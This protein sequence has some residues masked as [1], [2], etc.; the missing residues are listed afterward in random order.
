MFKNMLKRSWLSTVRKPSRT[1]ILMLVLFVMANMLLATIAIKGAVSE[2]VKYAKETLGGVVYLQPDMES[3]REK[4]MANNGLEN[5]T[6]RVRIERPSIS[7]ET[8]KKIADSE[9]VKD[10]TYS[11]QTS[12]N[13]SGFEL[14]E[15]EQQQMRDRIKNSGDINRPGGAS[16]GFSFA[17]GDTSIVGI[18]SFAFITDVETGNMKLS[19]GKIFDENTEDGVVV[20]ADLASH[21][22]L[23]VGSTIKLNTTAETP[24]EVSLK[25]IGIF[26]NTNDSYDPNTIY[27]NIDTAAKLS[28]DSSNLGVQSVKYYLVNAEDKDAFVA[29]AKAKYPSLETDGLKIDIDTS[30]YDQM[31]GPI[32][33]VGSFATTILWVVVI[34]SI[35]IITLIV[36]INVKDRRYEMGV[37]LSLGAKRTNILGQVLLELVLVGTVAFALSIGTGTFIAR[38]MGDGLLKQQVAMNEDSQEQG[39]GRGQ[40]AG[41]MR[42]GGRMMMG[43]APAS[44]RSVEVIKEIDVNASMGDYVTLFAAGYAVLIVALVLPSINILRYQP[45]TILTSKE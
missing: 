10:Y 24:E 8:A 13:A 43:G 6:Q 23:K 16:G 38:A 20:S 18:N 27:A 21:N 12:A 15:T 5:S 22:S 45:K 1:V 19:D 31:V 28:S 34:A 11:I 29:E 37:L 44:Q 2:S 30:A 35:V 4:A 36:T 25:I 9:Y 42:G 39:F 26:E 32:E 17:S 40:N 14:V 3:L 7:I 33:S 41:A